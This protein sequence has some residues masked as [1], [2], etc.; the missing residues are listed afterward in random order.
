VEGVSVASSAFS[1]R[2]FRDPGL[3]VVTESTAIAKGIEIHAPS[4][5]VSIGEVVTIARTAAHGRPKTAAVSWERSFSGV[6][7]RDASGEVTFRCG[8]A[9]SC[10]PRAAITAM[11][12]VLGTRIRVF[13]PEPESKAT[14]KGAFASVARTDSDYYN[15]LTVNNDNS[16]A[17]PGLEIIVFNDSVEKSRL[18][19]QLAGVQASSIYGISFLPGPGGDGLVGGLPPQVL[20]TG[21]LP[22]IGPYV[23]GPGPS[24][25]PPAGP[26]GRLIRSALFLF[27]SPKDA[28]LTGLL[29]L[30][31]AGAGAAG[32]RR[33]N[34]VRQLR[35]GT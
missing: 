34:L 33:S 32:W 29:G 23:P 26:V 6:V 30:L 28:L 21:I 15:A 25:V 18:V 31:F 1:G 2:A 9:D 14:P 17:V 19:V 8:D 24:V 7:V 13:L 4:G 10:D 12:E 35:E 20:P 27:R 22:S 5:S 11:N 16:R 3:G